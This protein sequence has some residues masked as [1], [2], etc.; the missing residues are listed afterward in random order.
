[1]PNF[2]RFFKSTVVLITLNQIAV[3]R[4]DQPNFVKI[5][6]TC[7]INQVWVAY[8]C[9][10]EK[11]KLEVVAKLEDRALRWF[12]ANPDNVS[13]PLPKLMDSMRLIFSDK[14]SSFVKR[15]RAWEFGQ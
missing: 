4:P 1:M 13:M 8:K 9:E 11:L 14:E 2:I 3:R 15:K 10:E 12:Q 6:Y 7:V 5:I